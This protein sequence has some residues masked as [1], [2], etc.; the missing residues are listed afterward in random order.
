M[1]KT[2][3][4][5]RRKR[6][7]ASG[8]A[9]ARGV[10]KIKAKQRTTSGQQTSSKAAP[11]PPRLVH[12]NGKKL[13]NRPAPRGQQD[14]RNTAQ[15]SSPG[16]GE[17]GRKKKRPRCEVDEEEAEEDE[18]QPVVAD[19]LVATIQEHDQ[20]FSRM[21]D[22]IPQHLVLPAKE[23]TESSYASKYMKVNESVARLP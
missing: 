14:T 13:V 9:E 21:L 7:I 15:K 11:G 16:R 8:A 23:V 22:M 10:S 1:A 5:E 4:H 18:A 12:K 3:R 6:A 19:E 20:F 2:T 17:G